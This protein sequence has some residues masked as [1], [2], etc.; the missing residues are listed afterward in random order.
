MGL[1]PLDIV[2]R[3]EKNLGI[4]ISQDEFTGIV[5]DRDILVGDLYDLVLEKTDLADVPTDNYFPHRNQ[6]WNEI[7]LNHA[8]WRE[9]RDAIHTATGESLQRIRLATPLTELFPESTRLS[10]WS[11]LRDVCRY[12]LA[13]LSYPPT[14]RFVGGL[15][16]IAMVAVH[17]FHVPFLEFLWPFL[18]F[19]GLWMFVETYSRV[20]PMFRRFRTRFPPGMRTV[21]DLC[22]PAL[23]VNYQL[24]CENAEVPLDIRCLHVWQQLVNA[25]TDSLGID[26]DK[27][28]FR[29]RLIADLGMD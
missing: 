23:M 11:R 9:V 7:R 18:L 1:D 24:L 2:F 26:E 4:K 17:L 22:R 14:V 16:A 13:G 10:D 6:V 29:S 25:L 27:I 8:L 20:L 12:K 15:L 5:R 19:I 28:T 3:L 21:K